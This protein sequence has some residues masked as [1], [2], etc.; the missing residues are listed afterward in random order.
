MVSSL[1]KRK[2]SISLG[3][4]GA[5]NDTAIG[6]AQHVSAWYGGL[7]LNLCAAE[8]LLGA[9]VVHIYLTGW[10][11]HPPNVP[12]HDQTVLSGAHQ[13]RPGLAGR[14]HDRVDWLCVAR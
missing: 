9:T 11:L 13:L 1:L 5:T 2:F 8:R 6:R 7:I 4:S 14:P 3:F 10:C 12:P